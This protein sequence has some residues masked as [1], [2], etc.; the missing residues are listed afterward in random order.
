MNFN[1]NRGN[2]GQD[3][4]NDTNTRGIQLK[5]RDSEFYPSAISVGY[6]NDMI[7]VRINPALP[8]EQ[9]T[10]SAAFD[11]KQFLNTALT[12]EKATTLVDEIET[13]VYKAVEAEEEIFRG[14]PLGGDGI[15]GV[16][17]RKVADKYITIV[18][19]FRQIDPETRIPAK[20]SF[21]EF[22][23]GAVVENYNENTGELAVKQGVQGELKL[24]TDEI[25]AAIVL[26]GN[27]AA[28]AQAVT[29]KIQALS[30]GGNGG[31]NRNSRPD[32]FGGAT[33]NTGRSGGSRGSLPG[34]DAST[35]Q[36]NNVDDMNEFMGNIH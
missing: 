20:K 8:P 25:K 29:E 15:I 36:M 21:Y 30:Q 6:W 3:R 33:G 32:V 18:A 13:H 28:H 5:N 7:S 11:W 27:A 17:G 31:Y 22:K 19:L 4:S 9:Q 24:F 10:E 14:V 1:G 35:T 2:N 12:L 16:G 26:L 34:P 23:T